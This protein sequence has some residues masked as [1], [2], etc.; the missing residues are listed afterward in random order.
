LESQRHSSDPLQK[1]FLALMLAY[2]K[3][4]M[5]KDAAMAQ[6]HD[7]NLR[8]VA[9]YANGFRAKGASS[10]VCRRCRRNAFRTSA[11]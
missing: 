3:G 6:G 2:G 8:S 9:E 10:S 1:T 11:L 5:V 7:V 4:D